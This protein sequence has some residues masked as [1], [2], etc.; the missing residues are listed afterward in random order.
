MTAA[1]RKAAF[2]ARADQDGETLN[3]AAFKVCGVTWMHLSSGIADTEKRPMSDDVKQKFAAY[4]G[5]SVEF[6]FGGEQA[7]SAA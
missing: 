6:V 7:S 3:A 5:Q 4:I 2:R 1:E